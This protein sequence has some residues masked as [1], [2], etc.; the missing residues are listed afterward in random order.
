MAE[1][2]APLPSS[3]VKS[4]STK[5]RSL[6]LVKRDSS[7]EAGGEHA[8]KSPRNSA[9]HPDARKK[10]SPRIPVAE[11]EAAK[12]KLSLDTRRAHSPRL[13]DSSKSQ[14]PRVH[15]ECDVSPEGKKK[16][17]VIGGGLGDR[18]KSQSPRVSSEH[19][20]HGSRRSSHSRQSSS[21]EVNSGPTPTTPVL[22]T[23][24]RSPRTD[25]TP[26]VEGGMVRS[27]GGRRKSL[28]GGRRPS[29]AFSP[30]KP[31]FISLTAVEEL[32]RQEMTMCRK[33]KERKEQ[34]P[35]EEK[36][37]GEGKSTGEEKGSRE[38]EGSNVEK[39]PEEGKSTGEEKGSGEG[40]VS[41][42]EKGEK[43]EAG[44]EAEEDDWEADEGSEIDSEE[45]VQREL[46]RIMANISLDLKGKGK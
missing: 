28:G 22:N 32:V 18:A 3:L 38:G 11:L 44:L 41:K 23:R 26:R 25:G 15:K 33:E 7:P 8:P 24:M 46:A 27:E 13:G 12:F 19:D 30:K 10:L 2:E 35:G 20:S 45:E 9:P 6:S 42:E 5:G 21:S 16:G 37:P 40:E 14:S 34:E 39:E 29:I 17:E 31:E 4:S 36:E 43:K 1:R